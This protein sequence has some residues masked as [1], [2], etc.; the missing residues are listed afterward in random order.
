MLTD[1]LK[2]LVSVSGTCVGLPDL[3]GRKEI[4]IEGIGARLSGT[5]FVTSTSHTI[6]DSGYITKFEARREDWQREEIMKLNPGV[7]HQASW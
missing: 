2:E 3:R 7:S 5:Y 4:E 6:N 1:Q